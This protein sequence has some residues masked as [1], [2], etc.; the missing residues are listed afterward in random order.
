M[1]SRNTYPPESELVFEF[2]HSSG[3]GGQNV[4]KVSTAVQLRFV[5]LESNYITD[6]EK[7]RLYK[8][9]KKKI[10]Q[11]G[12]LVILA[13]KYR[14]QD[15]NKK[16]AIRRL[17]YMIDQASKVSPHRIQTSP[18]ISSKIARNASKRILGLKKKART[19]HWG[20]DS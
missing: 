1:A 18:T 20:I 17:H 8:L 3:P 14:S 6:A 9:Y 16:D 2:I 5:I 12:E 11:T 19:T 13:K 4:N 7:I 10:S 15:Q